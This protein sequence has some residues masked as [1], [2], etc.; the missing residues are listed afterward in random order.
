MSLSLFA[1][2]GRRAKLFPAGPEQKVEDRHRM[3]GLSRSSPH[4]SWL[5]AC[6]DGGIRCDSA[7]VLRNCGILLD[8]V[9]SDS[10]YVTTTLLVVIQPLLKMIST[11]SHC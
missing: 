3:A 11:A 9:A 10:D 6:G 1:R 8:N 4:S 2:S 7:G 5:A